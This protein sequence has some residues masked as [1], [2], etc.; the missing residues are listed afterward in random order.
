MADIENY[1][2]CL[3]PFNTTKKLIEVSW[4]VKIGVNQ[5]IKFKYSVECTC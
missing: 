5:M 1:T 4:N 3:R 2:K